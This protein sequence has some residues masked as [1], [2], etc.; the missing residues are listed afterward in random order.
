[1]ALVTLIVAI[2][3]P[4]CLSFTLFYEVLNNQL[5]LKKSQQHIG[6]PAYKKIDSSIGKLLINSDT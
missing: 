5:I 4:S 2:S 1:M 6:S 3:N